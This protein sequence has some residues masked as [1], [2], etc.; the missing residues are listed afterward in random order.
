MAARI[1]F[2]RE[3]ADT[4]H[5]QL[6]RVEQGRYVNGR[7]QV[8]RQLNGDQTDYGLNVGRVDAAGEVPVVLRV[9][10]GTY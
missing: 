3:A 8:E 9:R 2:F 7:W 4:R 1:E 6:L 10:V 5:G